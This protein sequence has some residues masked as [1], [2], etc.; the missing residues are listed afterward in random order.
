MVSTYPNKWT[1]CTLDRKDGLHKNSLA[2]AARITNNLDNK[3]VGDL[4]S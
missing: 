1:N 4:Y 2:F 3:M